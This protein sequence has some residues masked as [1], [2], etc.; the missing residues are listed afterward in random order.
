MRI[1]GKDLSLAPTQHG[2]LFLGIL[3]AM[4]LGSINYNNNAGF[5]LVF[6]LGAMGL[7]SLVHSYKNLIGIKVIINRPEPVFAGQTGYFPVEIDHPKGAGLS[8]NLCFR[9]GRPKAITADVA[10]ADSDQAGNLRRFVPFEA[11]SRGRHLPEILT[12]WSVYPFG[13]FRLTA[14]IKNSRDI[15][16]Y[17][18]PEAGPYQ[19]GAAGK[20]LDGEEESSLQGPDDFQG[21]SPYQP[22]S[23]VGHISWKTLSRG[24]GL[25]VKNFTA[26]TGRD[27]LLD[28]DLV[29]AKDIETRLSILCQAVLA[30]E[31][32]QIPFGL[33]L[34]QGFSAP[35][36]SGR[37][38]LNDCL[39]ALALHKGGK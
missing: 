21:L 15:L 28:I 19:T 6:L 39:K 11:G 16:V 38:H 30:A 36:K 22:G 33:K 25:F 7:I 23:P 24:K 4:L 2:V 31:R 20:T 10:P 13:L 12:L 27:L 35:P 9:K 18:A 34:G 1:S 26:E 17:P 29:S 14:R 8:L 32:S 3:I 37:A 5:I